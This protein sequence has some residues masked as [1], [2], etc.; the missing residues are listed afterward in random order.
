MPIIHFAFGRHYRAREPEKQ[1]DVFIKFILATRKLK[2]G[3][4]PEFL[5]ILS[6]QGQMVP[7][8]AFATDKGGGIIMFDKPE[9]F[10]PA[11]PIRLLPEDVPMVS[12][13]DIPFNKLC[14]WAPS[15]HYGRLGIAFTNDFRR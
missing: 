7:T 11:P 8:A 12:F 1:V 2:A 3:I 4:C 13:V 9:H 10:K 14:R 15:N 5:P 6:A